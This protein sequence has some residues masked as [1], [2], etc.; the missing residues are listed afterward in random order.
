MAVT[1]SDIANRAHVSTSTVSRV[2][3][4]HPHV[5]EKT[6]ELIQQVA[7]EL[8]YPLERLR[9][10]SS[11]HTAKNRVVLVLEHSEQFGK[12]ISSTGTPHIVTEGIFSVFVQHG[13][14]PYR[15]SMPLIVTSAD[16]SLPAMAHEGLIIIGSSISP[17][18]VEVIQAAGTPFVVV[19]GS[20]PGMSVNCAMPDIQHGTLQAIDFLVEH[21]HHRIGL[22]NGPRLATSALEKYRAYRLGLSLHGLPFDP[23]QAVHGE[24]S[25]SSGFDNTHLLMHQCP[26]VDAI[27][28]VTDEAAIGGLR[29]LRELGHSTP[30]DVAVIGFNNYDNAR[31]A[32][33]PLTTIDTNMRQVGEMAAQR[34]CNLLDNPDDRQNWIMQAPTWLVVRESV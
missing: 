6:R 2:L 31:F 7:K 21:G 4:N 9:G 30:D 28:Y 26:D 8:E 15:Y 23:V 29:A 10:S 22:V 24:F 1:L 32:E 18:I 25:P 11:R 12:H 14:W 17:A 33:P 34:L 16:I 19:G 27:L 3:N 20:I 13:L 5:D